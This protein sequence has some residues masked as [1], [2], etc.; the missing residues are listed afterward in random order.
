MYQ[1]ENKEVVSTV[2]P[3]F[4][5]SQPNDYIHVSENNMSTSS[6]AIEMP[7]M[8]ETLTQSTP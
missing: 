4:N 8:P 7:Q 1:E 6:V 5:R 3:F 2:N